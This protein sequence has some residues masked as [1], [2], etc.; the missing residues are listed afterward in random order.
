[1]TY[2]CKNNMIDRLKD[3]ISHT[4]V[5]VG[6]PI[7]G[8]GIGIVGICEKIAPVLTVVSLLIGIVLGIISFNMKR[9]LIRR[10]LRR[11]RQER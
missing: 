10:Q 6:A 2:Y 3:T 5:T 8:A 7:S 1:M 11:I 9:K 4:A